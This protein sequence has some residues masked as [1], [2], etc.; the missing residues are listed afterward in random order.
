M[1][2][3]PAPARFRPGCPLLRQPRH[4]SPGH[5]ARG[6]PELEK[7]PRQAPRPGAAERETGK[8]QGSRSPSAK[9]AGGGGK[10]RGRGRQGVL[11]TGG[12]EVLHACEDS[13]HTGLGFP[14]MDQ[15][16]LHTPPPHGCSR[17]P[18]K[19]VCSFFYHPSGL[20]GIYG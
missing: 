2:P 8:C 17:C 3:S 18:Q 4:P 11:A 7:T 10:G 12:L 5:G 13:L 14:V 20:G 6:D 9:T 19:V 15:A 1:F 16:S